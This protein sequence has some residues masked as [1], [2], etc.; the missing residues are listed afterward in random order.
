MQGAAI[1]GQDAALNTPMHVA[2][3]ARH[4]RQTAACTRHVASGVRGRPD[5]RY[6]SMVKL[7]IGRS[8]FESERYPNSDLYC[9]LCE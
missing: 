8:D 9:K 5:M 2:A 4:R 6:R 7:A 1:S 3:D